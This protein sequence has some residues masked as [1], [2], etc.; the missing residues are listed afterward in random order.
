[1]KMIF[2]YVLDVSDLKIIFPCYEIKFL[3]NYKFFFAKHVRLF[4]NQLWCTIITFVAKQ[5]MLELCVT[6]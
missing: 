3:R 1:M 2:K 5:W 4:K 6:V